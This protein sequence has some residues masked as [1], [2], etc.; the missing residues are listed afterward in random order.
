MV[1]V[2]LLIPMLKRLKFGQNIRAEGPKQH[3]KK[4]GTPTMGGLAFIFILI[5]SMLIFGEYN[6]TKLMAVG[7]TVLYGCLGFL[8]DFIK[9]VKKRSLGL[10]A[11]QKMAGEIAIA[12]FLIIGSVT[13]LGRGTEL[14]LF[15]F[16]FEAGVFYYVLAF[17]LIAGVT[18]GVNLNDG[19]DGLAA[20]VS[21]FVYLGY[22]MIAYHCIEHPPIAGVDYAVLTAFAAVM[23]GI[24]L[25]F[26]FFNHY[27][28]KVF[29][30]DTGSL[31]LG[32]G[33][34]VLSILTCTEFLLVILGAVYVIEALSVMIQVTSFKTTGKRVFLMTPIHHHFEQLGWK[35][36]K[37]VI[38]F[39]VASLVCVA[40]G[41]VLYFNLWV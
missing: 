25:A 16:V 8:D 32:G 2:P 18:N 19:L 40:W 37:V 20:G 13:I 38:M 23:A 28:A 36:T 26:L 7:I 1:V 30:G 22:G 4:S 9:T 29:M 14:N 17:I 31:F 3:L 24:C 11:Y 35:E 27:P 15:G 21:F 33:L 41:L 34:A 10:R 6:F 5:L 12:L 39:W